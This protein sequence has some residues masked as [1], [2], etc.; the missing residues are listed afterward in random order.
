[1]I[2]VTGGLGMIGAHTAAALVDRG[3][4]VVIT[5]HRATEVPS[6]LDGRVTVEAL[7][8][9]DREAFLALA[10]RHEIRD[11]VHLAGSIPE[12]DPVEFFRRDTAGIFNALEAARTWRVRRFAVASSIGVYTGRSEVPW[13]EDLDL[14]MVDLPHAI[15]AF[16]KA[17]EPL[18][19]FG[20]AGSGVHP[21]LLRIG[22]TWGPLMD[23]VSAF[24]LIPPAVGALRRGEQPPALHAEDGGDFG[25]APDTGRAIALLMTAPSLK[26]SVY[27]VSSGYR[28]THRELADALRAAI[29]GAR[30]S[31]LDGRST[32]VDGDPYL[33]ISRL[34]AETGFAPQ[35][36]V[37]GAVAHYVAWR[38]ANSR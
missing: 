26:H 5:A 12:D 29:P 38:A 17:V 22:S 35:F 23:P 36:D 30:V 13:T 33:D 27:N 31:L 20:L 6:F 24:N 15:V 1:M 34:R 28:Y 14:P 9:T 18:T 4:E 16:K 7:D 8:A 2:L 37:M 10:D 25:Y 21:V 11:I 32:G 3:E 19:M